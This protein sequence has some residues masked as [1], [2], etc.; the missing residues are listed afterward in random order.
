M[1][2]GEVSKRSKV[3]IRSLRYYDEIGLLKPASLS[4]GSHRLYSEQDLFKLQQ[5]V[6]LKDLGFPLKQIRELLEQQSD[7]R[8]EAL[9]QQAEYLKKER[10]RIEQMEKGM[11][12]VIRS[13]EIEGKLNWDI[14]FKLF[15]NARKTKKENFASLS[16]IEQEVIGRF[17]KLEAENPDA[18]EWRNLFKQL[19]LLRHLPPWA[20]EIQEIV[21]RMT[22]KSRELFQGDEELMEK[23]WQ[24][25]KNPKEAYRFY[26]I[27][28]EIIDLLEKAFDIYDA[29]RKR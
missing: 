16:S 1:S 29:S 26:P 2:I 24:M 4:E 15:Q 20:D 18:E 19:N 21:K 17:P 27:D 9:R 3:S 10:T 8:I 12:T 14:L 5:I 11:Q 28:A 6:F 22:E 25:R 13:C 7:D 23:A